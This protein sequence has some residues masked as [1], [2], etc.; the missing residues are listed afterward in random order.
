MLR[1]AQEIQGC[2]TLRRSD[3]PIF[4][5]AMDE[6]PGK[7]VIGYSGNGIEEGVEYLLQLLA[8]FFQLFEGRFKRANFCLYL[9]S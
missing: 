2:G 7:Y 4:R 6:Y 3:A 5:Q 9:D 1:S 8:F